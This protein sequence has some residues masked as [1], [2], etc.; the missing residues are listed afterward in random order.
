MPNLHEYLLLVHVQMIECATG[1]FL[2]FYAVVRWSERDRF[3][4]LL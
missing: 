3:R 2:F 1:P 4:H